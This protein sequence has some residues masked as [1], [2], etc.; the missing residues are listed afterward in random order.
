MENALVTWKMPTT[1][2]PPECL[3]GLLKTIFSSSSFASLESQQQYQGILS[4]LQQ[5]GTWPDGIINE[6]SIKQRL[7]SMCELAVQGLKGMKQRKDL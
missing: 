7:I 1:T 5:A 6:E 2:Q 4:T 3:R